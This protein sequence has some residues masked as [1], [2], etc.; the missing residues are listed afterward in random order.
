MTTN[1]SSAPSTTTGKLGMWLT[2][3][4]I[5][6]IVWVF[7]FNGQS[8]ATW[9]GDGEINLFPEAAETKNY[10]LD[11]QISVTKEATGPFS[12]Q[13][14]Y[15]ITSY[16]WPEANESTEFKDECIVKSGSSST[17]TANDGR[18]YKVEVNKA[19][20]QPDPPSYDE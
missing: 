17:C 20:L 18:K 12:F 10:R 3:A 2:G 5:L 19:P 14:V 9:D 6:G 8:T 11:A 16:R 15:K 4:I 13:E 7:W 1:S